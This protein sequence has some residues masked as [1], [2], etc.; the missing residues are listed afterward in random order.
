MRTEAADVFDVMV[1]G[2]LCIDTEHLD[3]Q[4]MGDAQLR[5][6]I[7]GLYQRQARLALFRLTATT[8]ATEVRELAHSIK[9]ASLG[10]G[11][12]R[13]AEAAHQLE[14]NAVRLPFDQLDIRCVSDAIED[15]L[16]TIETLI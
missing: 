16:V 11:A 4:T 13:V 14:E 10:I 9:G 12:Q 5:T 2:V 6:E 15:T 7:L 3:R 1:D 8:S